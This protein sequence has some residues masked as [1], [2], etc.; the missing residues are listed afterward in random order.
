MADE[1]NIY[2][3]AFW[4]YGVI[5]GLAIKEALEITIPHLINPSRLA[6]ELA[7]NHQQFNF[8]HPQYSLYPELLRLTVFLALVIRFYLGSAYYFGTA[9]DADDADKKYQKKSYGVDFVFGF[10][11]FIGFVVLALTI[12]IHTTPFQWFGYAVAFILLYDFVWYVFSYRQDTS[13]LIFWWMV[14]NG[15]NCLGSAVLYLIVERQT[16]DTI[17]AEIWALWPVLLVSGF[18]IGW[19]MIKRPFFELISEKAPRAR[20]NNSPEPPT[21]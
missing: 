16:G 6:M 10:M 21:V 8:P 4:L 17:K 2:K 5:I 15:V 1:K 7:Q 3:H 12:D 9:Y 18:D 19:M 14:V 20:K 13:D 11:H